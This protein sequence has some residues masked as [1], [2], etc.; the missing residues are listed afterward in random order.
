MPQIK[1]IKICESKRHC[2]YLQQ[3]SVTN[4]A[5]QKCL[6][7]HWMLRNLLTNSYSR[8]LQNFSI[9]TWQLY[10][11]RQAYGPLPNTSIKTVEFKQKPSYS[12]MIYKQFSWTYIPT[13]NVATSANNVI[14]TTSRG[15]LQSKFTI[16]GRA[17]FCLYFTKKYGIV[18]V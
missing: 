2:I 18:D 15:K 12:I 14:W 17:P 5:A 4:N 7:C 13:K 1:S 3:L 6:Q 10:R 16:G 11:N 9:S 8:I